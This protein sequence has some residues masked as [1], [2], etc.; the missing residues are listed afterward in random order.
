MAELHRK[1][2]S[3]D[4][5]VRNWCSGIA[6][7]TP[8]KRLL[9]LGGSIQ[10]GERADDAENDRAALGND[11]N[12]LGGRVNRS[13]EYVLNRIQHE[14]LERLA[15]ILSDE[16]LK[17]AGIEIRQDEDAETLP[18]GKKADWKAIDFLIK[19]N[20]YLELSSS[21]TLKDDER[22]GFDD[23]TNN[24]KRVR[25]RAMILHALNSYGEAT[26]ADQ[27]F[28]G[29]GHAIDIHEI[30]YLSMSEALEHAGAAPENKG[31]LADKETG[32]A[33][34]DGLQHRFRQIYE[35]PNARLL[36]FASKE[37]P[38]TGIIWPEATYAACLGRFDRVLLS[39][40]HPLLTHR[41]PRF[42][43]ANDK[44]NDT[45]MPPAL[46]H[47]GWDVPSLS[48]DDK[49]RP[50]DLETFVAF[51]QHRETALRLQLKGEPPAADLVPLALVSIGLTQRYS[52]LEFIGRVL[53]AIY[54]RP[55]IGAYAL[56]GIYHLLKDGDQAYLTDG[57]YDVTIVIMGSRQAN[58]GKS[59]TPVFATLC[60]SARH[61]MATSWSTGPRPTCFCRC[62][63]A[64]SPRKAGICRWFR[65]FASKRAPRSNSTIVSC[66]KSSRTAWKNR[67]EG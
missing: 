52:R 8:V 20:K 35:P 58:G 10:G 34:Q 64:C 55:K 42:P 1:G 51:V 26:S 48:E 56:D 50:D 49:G 62:S 13:A 43:R 53:Q 23:L 59:A 29:K 9:N 12:D 38:E 16:A 4:N 61:C 28:T 6:T 18:V 15:E 60:A 24:E 21:A 17:R 22:D 27:H 3:T 40:S 46:L 31:E 11:E 39:D 57:A 36:P 66:S 19:L 2:E 37:A 41:L 63:T 33:A 47:H 67:T 7:T 25:S 30:G 44:S 65:R 14:K 54:H 5:D 32:A 45:F